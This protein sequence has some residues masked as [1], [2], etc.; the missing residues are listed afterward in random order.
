MEL[1]RTVV[2]VCHTL[3]EGRSVEYSSAELHGLDN[4]VYSKAKCDIN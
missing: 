4:R 2:Q 1:D 3:W